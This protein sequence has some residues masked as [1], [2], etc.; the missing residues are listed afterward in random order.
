VV[1]EKQK[2]LIKFA[3]LFNILKHGIPMLEYKVHIY[4]FNF[5]NL[6][7]NPKLYWVSSMGSTMVQHMHNIVLE[8]TISIVMVVW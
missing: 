2:K 1:G 7:E 8:A 4:I 3:T 5:L 6:V